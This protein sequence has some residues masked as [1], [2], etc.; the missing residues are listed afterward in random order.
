MYLG[1]YIYLKKQPTA[2]AESVKSIHHPPKAHGPTE[3]STGI[4]RSK[5]NYNA[6]LISLLL[7]NVKGPPTSVGLHG[8]MYRMKP[9]GIAFGSDS[10]CFQL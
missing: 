7:Q 1:I 2:I 3:M 9:P 4:R 10:R 8:L 5:R 6:V